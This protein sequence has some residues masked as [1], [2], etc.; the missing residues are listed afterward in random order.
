M[1]F[2]QIL[3][4]IALSTWIKGG[5]ERHKV[6]T[7]HLYGAVLCIV[8]IGT[9]TYFFPRDKSL[10]YAEYR[11]GTVA[12]EQIISPA[13]FEINKS[14]AEYEQ[15]KEEKRKSILAQFYRDT[16]AE[17]DAEKNIVVFF[18]NLYE[19]R[20]VA[21]E[22]ST[23]QQKILG[24]RG[25]VDT[26]LTQQL[27]MLETR[28]QSIF[29]QLKRDN[30]IDIE[31]PNWAFIHEMDSPSFDRFKQT[32]IQILKDI[33]SIGLLNV[34]KEQNTFEDISLT[35]QEN[36][37]ENTYDINDF[38]DRDDNNGEISNRLEAAYSPLS[39]TISVGLET[40]HN[41]LFPN[42]KFDR[43]LT[44]KL[45]DEAAAKVPR[46][47]GY[48]LENEKIVDRHERITEE[49][50][51][52]IASLREYLKRER[53][54][55]SPFSAVLLY[56]GQFGFLSI[57]FFLFAI[58]LYQFRPTLIKGT[59]NVT[60]IFLVFL[61]QLLFIFLVTQQFRL[62][63]YL[64]PTTIAAML[65]AIL[66]DGG[67]GIFGTLILSFIVGGFMGND[68]SITMYSFAGG[69][70]AILSVRRIRHLTQFFKAMLYIF[71]AYA[72]VLYIIGITRGMTLTDITLDLFRFSLSNAILSPLITLGFLVLFEMVFGI[73][74]NMTLLELSDLNSPMLRDLAVRAPGTY[75]HS[76]VLGNLSEKAAEAIDANSLLARVGCYYHDIGKMVKPQYYIENEPDAEKKHEA[77]APSM[78]SLIISSHIRDGL[79]MADKYKLPNVIKDFIT[80]HHGTNRISFF[81]EKAVEK[82]KDKNINPADFCYPGPK[83]Q[84]K[85]AGIVM[86]ADGVEAS[87]RALKDPSPARIRERVESII[88][89]RFQE[90]QLDECELTMKDLREIT[91]SFIQILSGIF[92]VRIEYPEKEKIAV[93]EEKIVEK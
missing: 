17:N 76:I 12:S 48:V 1:R 11:I 13:T 72:V 49:H 34:S 19:Y 42:I 5:A 21:K 91:E 85:E 28:A 35:L 89:Q 93:S 53:L 66:F 41:F 9:G 57:F 58:Y 47:R 6:K 65:L 29:E 56:V 20:D 2:R 44:E 71:L 26:V 10:Q 59:K 52:K 54:L 39:D 82:S 27:S 45:Q 23:I 60:I 88:S 67:V 63:E 86:L 18:N 8:L 92:H 43:E 64:I 4:K 24:S 14:P 83:P 61:T 75:H 50:Y 84:T 46:A 87:T 22:L 32:C 38:F 77:L 36:M 69:A 25:T 16:E 90:G 3:K 74:T 79:D 70:A 62:S 80:Q 30:N 81:Y 51:R 40:V 55:Q 73:T 33:H 37:E 78:S 15:E 68:F 31:K 7:N